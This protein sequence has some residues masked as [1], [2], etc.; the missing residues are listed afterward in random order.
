MSVCSAE[1]ATSTTTESSTTEKPGTFY[2]LSIARQRCACFVVALGRSR[3]TWG[4][5]YWCSSLSNSRECGST[6]HCS[7]NIWSQQSIQKKPN[8]NICQY[9]EFTV[10]KL[11]A[12]LLENKTVVCWMN[13]K[14]IDDHTFLVGRSMSKSGYPAHVPCYHP[15]N[16]STK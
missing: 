2:D 9:C 12:I 7:T 1:V 14:F 4:P 15:R 6:E 5:S 10:D 8:D 11:R 13:I 3:C 16:R